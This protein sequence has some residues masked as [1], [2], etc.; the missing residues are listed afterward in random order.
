M[1]GDECSACCT[2]GKEFLRLVDP[3]AM[4]VGPTTRC[5]VLI[6]P[7]AD[8]S[9]AAVVSVRYCPFCGQSLMVETTRKGIVLSDRPAKINTPVSLQAVVDLEKSGK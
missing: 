3:W 2:E 7:H 8:S 5:W 9:G 1:K 6:V 4:N